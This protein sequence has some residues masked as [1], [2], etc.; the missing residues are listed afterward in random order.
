[1]HTCARVCLNLDAKDYKISMMPEVRKPRIKF[2]PKKN[3]TLCAKFSFSMILLIINSLIKNSCTLF[4][5]FPECVQIWFILNV[6]ADY[7][8]KVVTIVIAANTNY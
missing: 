8:V 5:H 7:G 6:M 2:L 1:M 3:C 4:A